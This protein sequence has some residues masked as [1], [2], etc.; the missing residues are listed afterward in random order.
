MRTIVLIGLLIVGVAACAAAGFT[1]LG[2]AGRGY[3]FIAGLVAV[4]ACGSALLDRR[5]A[6]LQ[7]GPPEGG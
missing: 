5:R 6:P 4:A 3:L 7:G 2:P 1:G